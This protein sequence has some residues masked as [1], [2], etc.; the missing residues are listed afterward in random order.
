MKS[1]QVGGRGRY[2]IFQELA[3]NH[4]LMYQMN[5]E[6]GISGGSGFFLKFNKQEGRNKRGGWIFSRSLVLVITRFDVV[7]D[8]FLFPS[9]LTDLISTITST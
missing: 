6:A 2:H 1:L 3:K 4:T 8:I 9:N 5:G 7:F